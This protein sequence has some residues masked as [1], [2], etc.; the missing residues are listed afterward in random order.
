MSRFTYHGGRLREAMAHYDVGDLPWMDLST[1]INPHVW[2]GAQAMVHDWQSLPD[3]AALSALERAAAA[4]FGADPACVCALPGTEIGLRMLR[5]ILPG[6]ASHVWPSYRTH[7]DMIARSTA[8]A[9]DHFPIAANGHVIL[10]NPNNPDGRTLPAAMLQDW[11][12]ARQGT[13]SGAQD[14]LIVDEA[15]ADADPQASIASQVAEGRKLIVFRSFGKFFGLAGVRLGSVLA[16]P[17]VLEQYRRRLGSWPLSAAAL[18]IG[19]AAYSDADWIAATR[20]ALRQ[21][22]QRLD[23]MLMR[24]G[25]RPVGE[26]PLFRLIETQDAAQLFDHLASRAIL[27]RPFDYNPHWLRIGL[28]ADDAQLARLEEALADA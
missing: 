5:D 24:Q 25:L 9:S 18:D 23:A 14:W 17:Y 13:P 7:G 19:R 12:T 3:E 2:P 26:C 8:I 22:A 28:P 15:F 20:I 16:P 6:P 4:Y 27:T 11:L 1:G 10:A 21:S